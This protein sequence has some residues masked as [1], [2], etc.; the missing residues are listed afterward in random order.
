MRPYVLAETNWKT[1][2]ETHYQVAILP[3]GATEAHNY[4]LP[5]ATDNALATHIATEAAAFAWASGARTVVLPT[6]PFGVNTGQL[7]V[8][9]DLN[10]MP[11][12]QAALL[13]DLADVVQRAG[14]EKM[15]LLNA[16]GGNDFKQILRELGVSFPK[17]FF[18]ILN[19]WKV[20]PTDGYFREPGDHAGALETAAMLH[21]HPE[22]VRPLDEAGPGKAQPWQIS[23][24]REGWVW[25]ERPWTQV[26]EDTGIGNPAEATAKQGEYF[27]HATVQKVGQFLVELAQTPR[28]AF[29]R[30][31]SDVV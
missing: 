11:S 17:L 27:I 15:L 21:L 18:C 12:T 26:T 10:M 31:P 20:I 22:W 28:E 16:H 4:H 2:R 29:F 23:G 1:V 30:P 19:W 7:D 14:I 24:L 5:Y 8:K 6:V 25:A 9:L 13:R 3:W